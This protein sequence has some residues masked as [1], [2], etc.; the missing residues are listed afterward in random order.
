MA[1]T[2]VTPDHRTRTDTAAIEVA[3]DD[4]TPHTEDIAANPA[5]TCHTGHTAHIAVIQTTTLETA[6][7]H[8]T[9]HQ[10]T[11][12]ETTVDQAHNHPTAHQSTGHTKRNHA[13]QYHIPTME[14]A[15]LI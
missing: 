12:L 8:I 7:E 15:S 5:M 3:Q 6:A 14:T 13:A 10:D 4:L 9:A 2:E 1:C 11:T